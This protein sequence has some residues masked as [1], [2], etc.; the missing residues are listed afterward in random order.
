MILTLCGSARFERWFH[1]WNEAL[2]LAGHAAFG[3]CAYPSTHDGEKRWYS[4]TQKKAMDKVHLDKIDA[5]H[6]VL[7]LN[8][9]AYLGTST[10]NELRYAEERGKEIFFLQSWGKGCGVGPNHFQSVRAA[11]ESYGVPIGY[12]S[13]IDTTDYPSPWDRGLVGPA[14]AMRSDIVEFVQRATDWERPREA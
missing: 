4:E 11:A 12:G 5:S 3:L 2:G 6:A 13:P 7:I 8:P 10:M 1:A 9:Y 14:G